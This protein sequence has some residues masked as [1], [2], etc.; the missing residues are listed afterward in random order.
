LEGGNGTATGKFD[1]ESAGSSP[2]LNILI[3]LSGCEIFSS[4]YW[5]KMAKVWAL[6]WGFP[7]V[8]FINQRRFHGFF[9]LLKPFLKEK[10]GLRSC[11][12]KRFCHGA[13]KSWTF[14]DRMVFLKMGLS[15]N[16]LGC[17]LSRM[18]IFF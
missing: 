2:P 1:D 7:V 8:I 4:Q 13:F 14:L 11:T 18:K 10:S 17:F 5:A 9:G 6:Q 16:L 12:E 15:N 3:F